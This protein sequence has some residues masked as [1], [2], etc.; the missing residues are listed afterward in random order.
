MDLVQGAPRHRAADHPGADGRACRA[1]AGH[2][3]VARPGARLAALRDA[4]RR[5]D[6]R[7]LRR[8]ARATEPAVQRQLLLPRAARARRRRARPRGA[9]RWRRTTA[10]SASIP[11]RF[12]AGAGAR[13]VRRRGRRRRRGVPAGGGELPLRPARAALLARVRAGARACSPRRRPSRRRAGSRRAASTPSSPR[14]SRRAAIAAFPRR[15]PDAQ[16]G[17]LALVPQVVARGEGAGHRRRRHRRRARRR[18]RAAP[19]APSA[20][21]WAPPTCSAPRRRQPRASR[22]ARRA[23]RRGTPRSPT[24]SPAG[25]RAASSTG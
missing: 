24:S 11:R 8:S 12:A 7:E 18:G 6:A 13:A 14:G 17:T 9:R 3:R 16:V 4:R 5:R 23:R 21:R 2:R 25:R 20:C 22:G 19:S 1:R 15:R 10:S